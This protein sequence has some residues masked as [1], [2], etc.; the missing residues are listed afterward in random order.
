MKICLAQ[1]RSAPGDIQTNLQRHL[2]FIEMSQDHKSDLII[3]P[4]LSLTGYEPTMA[5]E[6]AMDFQDSR[7]NIFQEISNSRQITIGVGTPIRVSG[8]VAIG[9]VLFKRDTPR[10]V[11]F[12]RYLHQDEEPFFVSS[13]GF[14]GVISGDPPISLA[15]CYEISV[16]E[17]AERAFKSGAEIYMASVVKFTQGLDRALDRLST[18]ASHYSMVV[19]MVNAVGQADGFQCAGRSSVWDKQGHL[20][21]QLNDSDEGL[22]IL[23]T[24]TSEVV[25]ITC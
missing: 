16:P 8:G 22:L 13:Q 7:L 6:L 24:E 15:I 12:K 25:S 19:L 4:E 9:L 21:K 5:E 11:Y 1:S 3:F 23:N 17:H 10:K 20:V 18:I 14:A 2:D